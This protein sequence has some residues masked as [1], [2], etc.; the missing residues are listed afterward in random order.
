MLLKLLSSTFNVVELKCNSKISENHSTYKIV[1]APL[2][3]NKKNS[4]KNQ[5]GHS[6]N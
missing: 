2:N 1:K 5:K 6:K 3:S 4:L